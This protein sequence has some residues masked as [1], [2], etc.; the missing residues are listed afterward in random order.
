M[1]ANLDRLK[2]LYDAF[3]KG[4]V[5]AVLGAM[6]ER[7]EWREPDSLPYE[8]QVGPQAV[9]ENIFARVVQ[10]VH[11][12][13]VTPEEFIDGDDAIACAGRY[14]GRGAKTGL[15]FNTPF[16]HVWKFREGKI[17][18]FRTYTDTKVWADALG[19][20]AAFSA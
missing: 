15:S 18:Y 11:E 8:D 1:S 12:F 10:D 7:I 9:A 2:R 13:T 3:A 16:V 19:V 17:V 20:G 14:S 6:D 5:A 4:D